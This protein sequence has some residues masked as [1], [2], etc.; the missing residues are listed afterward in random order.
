MTDH[1]VER[2]GTYRD[3]EY[4]L[5]VRVEPDFDAPEEFAGIV[6]YKDTGAGENVEIAR[7]DTAH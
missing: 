6:Y 7:V 1:L 2:L 3:R 4:L 5:R